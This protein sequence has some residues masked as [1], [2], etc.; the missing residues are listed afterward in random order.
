MATEQATLLVLWDIDHTLI[1]TAGVGSELY[2]AAF[3]AVTGRSMEYPAD[4]TGR[5][6]PAIFAETLERHGIEATDEL[7]A[8]YAVELARQYEQH[9]ERLRTRGRAL[10]GAQDALMALAEQ[11]GVVQ[12]VL[13]GN[14]RA[15]A[16]TKL[17][18]Y[19]L[20]GYLDFDAG[21]FGEDAAKRPE[22]VAVAQARAGAKYG[23]SFGPDNTVIVGDTV[24]DVVAAREGGAA[25]V[26]V[27]TGRDSAEE[28]RN[29]GAQAVLSDL[30]D[31][32]GTVAA[33]VGR[34][35]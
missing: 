25:I 11:P 33:I 9:G 10:P 18:A 8:G 5:T 29:S 15:V 13:S 4:P 26:G 20:D 6:E 2:A 7:H 30:A 19:G 31:T 3:E 22:L 24:A 1:E 12:T 16:I 17:S 28:L 35:S 34:L 32:S 14:L 23:T 21:A 27:A